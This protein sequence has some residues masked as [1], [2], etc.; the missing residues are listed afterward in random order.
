M[1]HT[2]AGVWFLRINHDFSSTTQRYGDLLAASLAFW[3]RGDTCPEQDGLKGSCCPGQGRKK[4]HVC[5]GH[6]IDT[7]RDFDQL[8]YATLKGLEHGS[9]PDKPTNRPRSPEQGH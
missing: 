1:R 3:L 2:L 9:L 7:S 4:A 8:G 6:C 5:P